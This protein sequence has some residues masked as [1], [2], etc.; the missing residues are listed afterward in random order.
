M[1]MDMHKNNGNWLNLICEYHYS[2]MSLKN[3]FSMDFHNENLDG[4]KDFTVDLD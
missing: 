3:M 2:N 4:W 1:S